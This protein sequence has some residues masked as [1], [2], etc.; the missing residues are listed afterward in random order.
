MNK[1]LLFAAVVMLGSHP[2]I[3]QQATP[4]QLIG[5]WKVIA[6]KATSGEKVSYPVGERPDG[7][8]GI[9]PDR[10]WLLFVDSTRKA[11][12]AAA[13]T[14]PEAVAMMKSH[15][16]WTGKYSTDQ[17]PDGTKVTAHVDAASS[18]AITGTDRVYFLKLDGK[19]LMMQTPGAIV[20]TTGITSI[21]EVQLVKAD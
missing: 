7:Y 1:K 4:D 15:V 5:T 6:V 18:Q 17:T 3:A 16:A 13:L 9:T 12:T 20:P 10:L 21:I 19:Y 2:S 8:L 14:D 11:P